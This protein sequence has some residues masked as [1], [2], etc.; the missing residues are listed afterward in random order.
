MITSNFLLVTSEALTCSQW[1]E[2]N[3]FR[4]HSIDKSERLLL[5]M[6][7]WCE[8]AVW[9]SISQQFLFFSIQLRGILHRF[10]VIKQRNLVVYRRF[11]FRLFRSVL[12]SERL[13][14]FIDKTKRLIDLF[15]N[16]FSQRKKYGFDEVLVFVKKHEFQW[17]SRYFKRL[18][19]KIEQMIDKNEVIVNTKTI[20][21]L[22]FVV[23]LWII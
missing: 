6:I 20:I 17:D 12:L 2:E 16:L 5:S 15:L 9:Y 3:N 8:G 13:F 1:S 10:E 18:G 22:Q 7:Y 21:F 14:I 4:L 19:L 11:H 23:S